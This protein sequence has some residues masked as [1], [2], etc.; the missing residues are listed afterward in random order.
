M[1]SFNKWLAAQADRTDDVGAL[2]RVHGGAGPG[3][4][5]RQSVVNKYMVKAG[6]TPETLRQV[7]AA[8]DEYEALSMAATQ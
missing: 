8:F 6:T 5:T 1:I 4:V 7:N 3:R 2:A